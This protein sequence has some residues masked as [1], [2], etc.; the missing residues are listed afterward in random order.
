MLREFIMYDFIEKVQEDESSGTL[1]IPSFIRKLMAYATPQVEQKH[2]HLRY[3]TENVSSPRI[4]V[5]EKKLKKLFERLLDRAIVSTPPGGDVIFSVSELSRSGQNMTLEFYVQ[6]NGIG[7][8]PDEVERATSEEQPLVNVLNGRI[9]FESRRNMGTVAH[10]VL[11]VKA[12]ETKADQPVPN[13]SRDVYNFK[14]KRVLLVEDHPLNLEIAKNMLEH[15]GFVVDTAVDGQQA[16]DQFSEEGDSLDLILMDIRMPVKDGV[17]AT[18]EIR[19]LERGT[20]KNIPIIAL[21][22]SAYEGDV[23]RAREAGMND[24]ILK[25][26]DPSKMYNVISE[27]LYTKKE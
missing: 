3:R 25:P 7:M 26:I 18:Q 27:Y 13:V 4:E 16:V 23:N 6:D 24:S 14:G 1:D 20:G 22:A 19:S 9:S 15:V 8:S 10:I 17:E 5:D 11:T 2:L 12:V 21:T